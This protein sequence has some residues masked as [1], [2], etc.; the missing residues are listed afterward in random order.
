V[1]VRNIV[2]AGA[3]ASTLSGGPSTAWAVVTGG[4]ILAA[5]RAAGTLLPGRRDR[6]G[7][8]AGGVAHF[9]VS[10]AWT[11]ALGAVAR[12][13]RFGIAGGAL[14][15]L[16]IAA[17]DVGMIGRRYPAIR[18]LPQAPQWADNVAFGALF[19]YVLSRLEAPVPTPA[20]PARTR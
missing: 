2:V 19:G 14:A 20:D 17:I 18:S 5:T 15:G 11:A 1:T 16:V 4:E 13:R 6:P 9:V 10:A 12:R 3:V 7:I 8:V